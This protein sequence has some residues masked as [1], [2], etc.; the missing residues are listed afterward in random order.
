MKKKK[1]LF[2]TTF[3]ENEEARTLVGQ[4]WEIER[5]NKKWGQGRIVGKRRGEKN[6]FGK[7]KKKKEEYKK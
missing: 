3:K 1:E 6:S 4:I 2:K 5:K 7:K